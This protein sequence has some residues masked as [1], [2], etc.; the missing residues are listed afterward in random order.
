MQSVQLKII[1]TS[2]LDTMSKTTALRKS[3]SSTQLRQNTLNLPAFQ[4]ERA[5]GS[6]GGSGPSINKQINTAGTGPA[7]TSESSISKEAREFDDERR[8][9]RFWTDGSDLA[10]SSSAEYV[11][12]DPYVQQIHSK[13]S[14]VPLMSK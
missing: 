1:S 4:L 6:S 14:N 10:T 13:P 2:D 12:R 8:R 11:K 7:R 5:S 9:N 3:S